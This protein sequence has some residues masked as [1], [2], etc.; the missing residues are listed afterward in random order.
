MHVLQPR[1]GVQNNAG[2][3]A[4]LS[5]NRIFQGLMKRLHSD[6]PGFE[7]QKKPYKNRHRAK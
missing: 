2:G 5:G 7:A 4:A 3:I 1:L 6:R